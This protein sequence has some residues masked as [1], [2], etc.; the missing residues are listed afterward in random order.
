ML[1]TKGYKV[2]FLAA[3]IPAMPAACSKTASSS[4]SAGPHV[5][6]EGTVAWADR[7]PAEGITV[8][9]FRGANDVPCK[10]TTG[11]GGTFLL[12]CEHVDWVRVVAIPE[13]PGVAGKL[14]LIPDFKRYEARPEPYTAVE[15][16]ANRPPGL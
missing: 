3:L 8:E 5:V 9:G 12:T 4:A 13:I 6:L 2:L 16:F 7:T 1:N 14:E 10:T 11:R 15:L